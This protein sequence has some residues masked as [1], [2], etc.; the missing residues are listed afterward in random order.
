VAA[1]EDILSYKATDECH[2]QTK[3]YLMITFFKYRKCITA[4]TELGFDEKIPI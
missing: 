4:C 2:E 1:T 3:G